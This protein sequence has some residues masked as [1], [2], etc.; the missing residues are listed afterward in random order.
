MRRAR[1]G[2]AA[3]AIGAVAAGV[4]G[5]KKHEPPPAPHPPIVYVTQVTRKDVPLFIEA[6]ATLDGYVNADIRARVRGY[7]RSQDYKDGAAV[8]EGQLL[9]TI[10]PT[11]YQAALAAAD[12]ALA[13]ARAAL[14][15][16]RVQVERYQGL[17][18][19]GMVSQ[20]E[21][22]NVRMSLSETE[23]GV[24]S[25]VAAREQSVLDLSYT[26][27]RSPITGVAGVALVRIGNLVGQN[28]PTLLTTVSQL[29]P[30]RVTFPL[31]ESDYASYPYR[32][33]GLDERDLA[34][35]R[36]QFAKLDADGAAEGDDPGVELV[37]SDGHPYPRRGV[38][39]SANR[40]IDPSTGTI[41][42]QALFPNPGGELRPGQY[43][44]IR[45]R[46]K[47]A[48]R[49]VIAVPERALITLQ[50]TYSVAVVG[51][52]NKVSLRRIEVGPSAAGERIVTGGL[53]EGERIVAD[54]TQKVA[55][56]AVVDPRPA[57]P[58][59]P[60]SAASAPAA[61]GSAP[62]GGKP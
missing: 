3:L 50:G 62:P 29:D 7:L 23:A 19:T 14:A 56:G 44:R 36:E 20:Q 27:V 30:L 51:P 57:P 15:H 21:L 41:Q 53:S 31:A 58:A 18:R 12:A 1:W 43:G 45:L 40:Q 13:R 37:L 2:L 8:K 61:P 11:Q 9:F 26:R 38:V 42:L 32:A 17:V 48:G 54:G 46:R 59:P 55:D 33:K 5:C 47:D 4:P 6:V 28:E 60:G 10:E 25:A 52:D 22:D 24:R 16:D 35:A 34:W 39:V 49:A